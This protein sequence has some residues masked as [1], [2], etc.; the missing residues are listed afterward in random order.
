V[1]NTPHKSGHLQAPQQDNRRAAL[2]NAASR[3]HNAHPNDGSLQ[4]IASTYASPDP[5]LQDIG[6]LGSARQLRSAARNKRR[7]S[8]QVLA[9]AKRSSRF[10][11]T[12]GGKRK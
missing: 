4:N 11:R 8:P 1:R 5:A 3:R 10:R 12:P 7:P 6:Q 2:A 9:S